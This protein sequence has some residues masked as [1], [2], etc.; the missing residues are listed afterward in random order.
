[1][2]FKHGS[3]NIYVF[4]S[5]DQMS[6]KAANMIAGQINLKPETVLGLATGSTPVGTYKELIKRYEEGDVDFS[7]VKTF[8]L[9]EYYPIEPTNNQS[10]DYF[11]KENLFN[12][13]N[14]KK[15]NVHIPSGVS[16]DVEADCKKYDEMIEKSGN[17]DIQVLGI[18]VNGHIGFNEP[19]VKFET[20]THRVKL[21]EE[22]IISNS[23]FF[24]SKDEVPK[25]AVSMGIKNIM[26]SK[27]IIFLANGENKAEIVE[28]M[29]FGD[30]TPEVPASILQLHKDVTVILDRAAAKR[31]IDRLQK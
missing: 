31:I 28:K 27:K 8:N 24:N 30:V 7:E 11:M 1:M 9:D 13:I 4:D 3:L 26:N 29:L 20:G 16:K 12:H 15:E 2:R 21:D 5:Y 25:E 22:T 23:R 6:E 18:G 17:I 14:I 10:Y 19:D